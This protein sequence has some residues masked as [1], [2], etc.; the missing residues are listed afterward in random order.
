MIRLR[1]A[2]ARSLMNLLLN[3][4]A[5]AVPLEHVRL[6]AGRGISAVDLFISPAWTEPNGTVLRK[7][8]VRRTRLV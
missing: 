4:L 6:E 1:L 7:S 2:A 5:V 8:C 3:H